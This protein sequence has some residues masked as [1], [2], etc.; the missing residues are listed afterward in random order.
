MIDPGHGIVSL[1]LKLMAA[2]KRRLSHEL[3]PG[4]YP[5]KELYRLGGGFWS[6][7]FYAVTRVR[8]PPV[9]SLKGKEE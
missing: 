3:E 7:P 5:V 1:R 6:P 9:P 8:F 4:V 2:I